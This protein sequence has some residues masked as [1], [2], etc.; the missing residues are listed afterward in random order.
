VVGA[1]GVKRVACAPGPLDARLAFTWHCPVITCVSSP[2]SWFTILDRGA[3]YPR[4]VHAGHAVL[5]KVCRANGWRALWLVSLA[6]ALPIIVA[7][8]NAQTH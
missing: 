6:L 5:E 1:L 3:I 4:V 8:H 7:A 2:S